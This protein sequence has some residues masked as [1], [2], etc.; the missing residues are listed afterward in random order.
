METSADRDADGSTPQQL[1]EPLL[2][3]RA[4]EKHDI[5]GATTNKPQ[6]G[7]LAD[8]ASQAALAWPLVLNLLAAYA[9][10]IINM[11]FVG[12]LGKR[13]LAG[14]ALGN[15]FVGITARYVLQGLC[16]ALD[17]QAA[18]AYGAGNH[19]ALGPIFKR[20]LLFLWLHCLAISGLLLGAPSLLQL[21][22]GDQELADMAH[23]YI[24]GL[25]PAVWLD[26]AARPLNRILVAQRITRP[27]MAISLV[28]IPLHIATT[29]ALIFPAG[30]GYVGA[31]LAV[32]AANLYGVVLTS[33]YIL[34]AGL[35]DR[36]FGGGW[37]EVFQGWGRMASLAYPAM[38]M[39]CAESWGFAA[40]TVLAAKLPDPQTSVAAISVAFSTCAVAYMPFSAFGMTAC[41]QVGNCLGAGNAHGA[42]TA[43]LA[44]AL[45]G[46][47]LW[48][49]SAVL[50]LEPHCRA[51][52]IAVFTS[53]SDP[54]LLRLLHWL[55][56]LVA[57]VNLFDGVQTIMTG[58]IQGC[59]KQRYGLY[60]NLAVF[61]CVAV[62]LALYLGFV[63]HM[64][65][66]GMWLGMLAGPVMQTLAYGTVLY[67]IDWER[68]A[69][70][71]ARIQALL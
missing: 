52:V 21:L 41:T 42:R 64:G 37:R 66:V 39:K 31:A 51:G 10:S 9:T 71:A 33:G 34:W 19:A 32:G 12:H 62:P 58:V 15:S 1:T 54:E 60:I 3:E 4:E 44:S 65:V 36:V 16:G 43:A 28:I 2:A 26:A 23:R 49:A 67:R 47:L 14:A 6:D 56:L 18:Q 46:P 11:S 61:Y 13:E 17:T 27:Q 30:W 53:S 25:I 8:M 50:L 48:G 38:V 22:S 59:G 55:L 68:E 63:R 69:Q 35:G 7:L 40:M 57:A 5:E 29:W 24:L 45:V 70:R 20:T